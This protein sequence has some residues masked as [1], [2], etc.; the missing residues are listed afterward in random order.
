MEISPAS[1]PGVPIR[2]NGQYPVVRDRLIRGSSGAGYFYLGEN[3]ATVNGQLKFP[4]L[5]PD[6]Q[7]RESR[8]VASLSDN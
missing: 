7:S 2:D 4:P 8:P 5:T 6:A 3:D 1:P